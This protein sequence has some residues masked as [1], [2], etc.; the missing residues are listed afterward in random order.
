MRDACF[1]NDV[2]TNI[3]FRLLLPFFLAMFFFSQARSSL[4]A[5]EP[6]RSPED[7][8]SLM[9]FDE[10]LTGWKV[11]GT[12]TTTL[13]GKKIPV[14]SKGEDD[15]HLLCRGGGF[16][17]LR[18][19]RPLSDFNVSLDFKIAQNCNSGVCFRARPYRSHLD[20]LGG[21]PSQTGYEIQILDDHHKEAHPKGSGALYRYRAPKENVMR[22]AGRW[23]SLVLKC[24]GSHLHVEMN[25]KV[26]H[27][28]DQR[29]IPRLREKPLDGYFSLQNHGGEVLFRNLKIEVLGEEES[30]A[31][32]P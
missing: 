28:F 15:H 23:N 32:D 1:R 3:S 9:T 30:E 6:R 11:E 16:G 4:D 29:D 5:E 19:E 21:R 24:R 31:P 26:L 13:D 22:P 20:F 17:F 27:D 12:E 8:T 18:F 14:W 10:V 25:G 2:L 7:Q